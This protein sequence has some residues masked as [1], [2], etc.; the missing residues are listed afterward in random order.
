MNFQ[1]SVEYL[2]SLGNEVSAMKLGLENIRKLLDVLG[3]PQKNYL[4]VQVAGTNGK[5]SVC[6]FLDSICNHT[7]IRTG[8]YT[9][10]HLVSITERI[11]INGNEISQEEF[12]RLATRI[13]DTSEDLVTS[14]ELENVPT[15]FEQLTAIALLAFAEANVELAILETGLGGRLDATTAANAEIA[16]I[17]QIDLDHQ[18]Y[19][20]NTIAEIAAEKAAIIHYKSKVVVS[21]QRPEAIKVILERCVKF[22][23]RPSLA[24]YV[25]AGPDSTGFEFKTTSEYYGE[26]R[27]GLI[28]KHQMSNATVAILLAEMLKQYFEISTAD[29]INGLETATHKGR[30][31]WWDFGVQRILFDGAHNVAGAI[32]LKNYIETYC[33]NAKITLVFGLMADKNFDEMA[34]VIFPLAENIVL[35]RPGNIRSADPETLLEKVNEFVEKDR[36]FVIEDV[37]Q[38]I[39]AAIQLTTT[40]T[41]TKISF[42]CVTGSLYLVGDVQRRLQAG[43]L[44]PQ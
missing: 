9:S 4:K 32:A 13:R 27:L 28:G 40:Y 16:A 26:V 24:R 36:L 5:G 44:H 42:T 37:W 19:L 30:L 6:A 8:L 21:E 41:V 23:I 31:E 14:G 22:G 1:S 10:P 33:P 12:A 25:D 18:E 38:A 7:G 35:T 2:Y 15:F 43:G 3:N 29:I 11:K 20:G 17:T 39:D 34:K